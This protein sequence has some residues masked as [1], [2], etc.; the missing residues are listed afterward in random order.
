MKPDDI[1]LFLQEN[2]LCD[3]DILFP[4]N[5]VAI[6]ESLLPA[7]VCSNFKTIAKNGAGCLLCVWSPFGEYENEA[8]ENDKLPL[9]WLDSEGVPKSVFA[10]NLA[11]ALSLFPYGSGFI[12]DLITSWQWHIED[13]K[14]YKSPGK[15]FT[16][17]RIKTHLKEL[18][19]LPE[20]Q[21][22]LAFNNQQ[23]ITTCADPIALVGNAIKNCPNLD[24]WLKQQAT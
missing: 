9:I 16:K 14:N 18:A 10:T 2:N 22:L 1:L 5:E 13:S 19:T 15:R 23:N 6:K 17:K 24:D 11:E 4:A 12:Y 8:A 3:L 7:R 20:F 21:Q